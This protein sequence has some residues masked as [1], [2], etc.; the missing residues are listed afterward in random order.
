[1]KRVNTGKLTSTESPIGTPE[2]NMTMIGTH[3]IVTTTDIELWTRD[4]IEREEMKTDMTVGTGT[5][6]RAEIGIDM[7]IGTDMIEK[8]TK[9]IVMTEGK[10]ASVEVVAEPQI[11]EEVGTTV[12]VEVE[13]GVGKNRQEDVVENAAEVG[14]EEGRVREVER[15]D[16]DT[17]VIV[18]IQGHRQGHDRKKMLI[19]TRP[20]VKWIN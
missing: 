4:E 12:E 3:E 10:E 5:D 16:G 6:M 2:T 11:D 13:I 15:T 17:V 9:K 18:I 7:T 19:R 1:M 20:K 14:T 8:D